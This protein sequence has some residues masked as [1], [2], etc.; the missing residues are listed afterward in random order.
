MNHKKHIILVVMA[1]MSMMSLSAQEFKGGV[2]AG[3]VVTQ[4]NGDNKGGYSKI[5]PKGGFFVRRTM[6]GNWNYQIDLVFVQKGSKYEYIDDNSSFYD[7]YNL[8]LRYIEAPV[9]FQYVTDKIEV[10]GL[11]RLSFGTDIA[12]EIG[13]G[14]AY[15]IEAKED[16]DGGGWLDKPKRPFR[17]YDITGH[18]GVAYWFSPK[19]AVNFRYSYSVLPVRDHPGEQTWLLDIGEYNNVLHF[20][21]YYAF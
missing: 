3:P 19:W 4:Y 17:K 11:F 21:L 9:T 15:L 18:V 1:I 5:G 2:C 16:D 10:P 6:P 14:A 8:R 7:Y 13:L 12:F 20:T